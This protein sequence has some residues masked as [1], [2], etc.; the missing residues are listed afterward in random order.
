MKEESMSKET[1]IMRGQI[2]CAGHD[3]H[4]VEVSECAHIQC[5]P[6]EPIAT[7]QP[8][9]EPEAQSA[10][11]EPPKSKLLEILEEAP[12]KVAR[13]EA[14]RADN[15][16]R[17]EARSY[18]PVEPACPKCGDSGTLNVNWRGHMIYC[19]RSA[20]DFKYYFGERNADTDLK[21]FAQFFHPAHRPQEG[22][23]EHHRHDDNQ[24]S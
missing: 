15:Y 23:D 18:P 8:Q 2:G 20:C 22:K 12:A 17:Y 4:H 10:G 5:K 24:T 13:M 19:Q 11:E 14:A 21:D 9:Q 7:P 3:V 1:R 6:L 16:M